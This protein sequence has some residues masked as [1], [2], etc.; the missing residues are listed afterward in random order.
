MSAVTL[1]VGRSRNPK[2]VALGRQLRSPVALISLLFLAVV[3]VCALFPSLI[4]PFDPYQQSIVRRLRPP[5][6]LTG[7]GSNWLGTDQLGRDILSRIIYGTR[8]TLAISLAAVIIACVIGALMGLIAGYAGGWVD[9]LVLRA[10]DAQLSFPV[11]LL[12]IAVTA[13]IGASVP[14]LIVLM[15]ISAW[16]QI[17]R[18]VRADV[19]SVREL[20][21]VEAARAIGAPPIRIILKHIA[22]NVLSALIVVATYE[23]SRMI[24]IEATL[25]FLGLGVQ[26]P[27]PTW[28]GMISEGQK[29]VQTAWAS[30]VF[31][32]A[33]ITF[34]IL[35]INMLGDA[36]RD[37]LDPRLA[38]EQT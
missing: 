5:S 1:T 22:P 12:V 33:A 20:E 14:V 19:I 4:A 30:S 18:I 21:Y 25:S 38:N 6:F 23:L 16:P 36:L 34:T 9:A 10:I 11:I 7:Q 2:L 17:A 31:P 27:T 13:A 26:P 15:G 28:G 3:L 24:L 32:G 35:A 29:Y 37:A 8:V